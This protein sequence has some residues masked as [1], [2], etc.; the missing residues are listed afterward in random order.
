MTLFVYTT[1]L[2]IGYGV[3]AVFVLL[4]LFIL[5]AAADEIVRYL[6]DKPRKKNY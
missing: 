6:T 5:Y 2:L 4:G 1:L 3:L